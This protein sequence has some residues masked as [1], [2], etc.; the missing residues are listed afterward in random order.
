MREHSIF[1]RLT[2]EDENTTTE[3]LCNLCKNE[4][5]RN[6]I[7]DTLGLKELP[8]E[9]DDIQ[10]QQS[11]PNERKIPDLVIENDKIK[12]FVENKIDVNYKLKISQTRVYPKELLKSQKIIK[13]IYLVPKG[14][15]DIETIEKLKQKYDF[16]L[17]VYWEDLIKK[18]EEFNK[19]KGSEIISESILLLNKILGTIP[20]VNF[21]M[22][23]LLFMNNI[24]NFRNEINTMGKEL[25]LFSNVIWKL[26]E[27]LNL[28]FK[29]KEPILCCEEDNFGYSF[30]QDQA[31][32]GYSFA[33]LDSEKA[34]EKEYVLNLSFYQDI[35]NDKIKTFSKYPY[36]LDEEYYFFKLPPNILSNNERE[37]LLLNY[38]EDIFKEVIII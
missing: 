22:E 35:V 19:D 6:I 9:F 10:T 4:E 12:I 21:T 3:L 17:L 31:Y 27:D 30:Y 38:C 20:K 8:I 33:W 2:S 24:E 37:Q 15:K 7:L 13:L 25:E 28:K 34:E 32:I 36:I 23:D 18:L 26:K 11:I 14:Y 29:Q 5:R 1:Y 16:I